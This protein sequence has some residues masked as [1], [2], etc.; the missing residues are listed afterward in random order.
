M[1][2]EFANVLPLEMS[3]ADAIRVPAQNVPVWRRTQ[4]LVVGG[5]AAGLAAAVSAA[6]GGAAVTLLE[7]GAYLGGLATG[8]LVILLL[9][10]DDGSGHPIIRGL[11]QEVVDRLAARGA[12]TFPPESERFRNDDQ[13]VNHWAER[14]LCWGKGPHHVRYSVS[15]DPEELILL[16]NELVAES[17]IHILFHTQA[18][19]SIVEKREVKGV[20]VQ[21][22]SRRRAVLADVVIDTTGDGD[23]FML[24]G[25]KFELQRVVPWLW[26]RMGNVDDSAFTTS[27]PL[28]IFR[29]VRPREALVV[30][31]GGALA[32]TRNIDP[33][34]VED[35]TWAE[36]ACR[37]KIHQVIRERVKTHPGLEKAFISEVAPQL[38]ITESRRLIGRR[39]LTTDDVNKHSADSIGCTGNW[40]KYREFYEIPYSC[41]LAA[42]FDNLLTAGRC[43]S[44]S[45]P[46]HHST[47]EIPACFVTGE[48]A[49]AA[50]ALAV[51]EGISPAL[52]DVSLL[53][54]Q[55]MQQ[56]ACLTASTEP[57]E[58]AHAGRNQGV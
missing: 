47:K 10:M 43:I 54:K 25:A 49:G 36:I 17:R 4:V 18:V 31:W 52:L 32:L 14:G 58:E 44:V 46:V 51:K 1:Q 33:T 5:G 28:K 55:L 56:G 27:G 39:V 24:A 6:R 50:A 45:H 16:A 34:D 22:R 11:C 8:G 26:F 7:R 13:L 19:D 30:P 48:A 3:T 40:S 15:F 37:E 57:R 12:A 38:D 20:I 29:T 23:V 35:L 2:G 42:E 41:L 9:T 21:G 53:R